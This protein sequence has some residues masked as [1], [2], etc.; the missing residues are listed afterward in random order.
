MKPSVVPCVVSPRRCAPCACPRG[1]FCRSSG[2]SGCLRSGDGGAA[3][4][5]KL[6]DGRSVSAHREGERV[7][8]QGCGAQHEPRFFHR[9]APLDTPSLP[10]EGERGFAVGESAFWLDPVASHLACDV[11]LLGAKSSR[12]EN[13]LRGF[14]CLGSRSETNSDAT[15]R[16]VAS[17][18]VCDVSPDVTR[19]CIKL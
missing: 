19:P 12:R 11:C 10:G 4:P 5:A 8:S 15:T 2:H 7:L 17:Y 9:E 6:R 14:S 3:E 16:Q 1:C 18:P 13:P